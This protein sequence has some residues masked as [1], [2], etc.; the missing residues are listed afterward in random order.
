MV[1]SI[2]KIS[3]GMFMNNYKAIKQLTKRI[4]DKQKKRDSSEYEKT[5]RKDD[6]D[7]YKENYAKTRL[8]KTLSFLHMTKPQEYNQ[9]FIDIT[10]II[11]LYYDINNEL[12]TI[13]TLNHIIKE[14]YGKLDADKLASFFMPFYKTENWK[15]LKKTTE[16]PTKNEE[17][18]EKF[19]QEH[20]K[21]LA[22]FIKLWD[23]N[24]KCYQ[25]DLKQLCTSFYNHKDLP[26][27]EKY[28]KIIDAYEKNEIKTTVKT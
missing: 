7:D 11:A 12:S 4:I 18:F 21:T 10:Y 25:T 13:R 3:G 23:L 28:Q 6:E 20:E 24:I 9:I 17:N 19:L 26:S 27:K 2:Q 1:F 15:I 8:N 22:L 16:K 5:D 14:K